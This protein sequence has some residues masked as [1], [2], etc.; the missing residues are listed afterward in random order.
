M[1]DM[2]AA[3]D[4][5]RNHC[6]LVFVMCAQRSSGVKRERERERVDTLR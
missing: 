1:R 2:R 4:R 5:A 3:Q 6:L